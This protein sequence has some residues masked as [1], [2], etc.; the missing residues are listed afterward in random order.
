MRQ[1]KKSR[2]VAGYC[3]DLSADGGLF[4]IQPPFSCSHAKK[5]KRRHIRRL[6]Q[7]CHLFAC[8]SVRFLT[9]Q[10]KPGLCKG[11]I[12]SA[13]WFF[14][15]YRRNKHNAMWGKNPLRPCAVRQ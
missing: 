10:K 2:F 11:Q 14:K 13:M 6:P 9:C 3:Y 12:Y 4:D 5:A 1:I 8:C 15:S 7:F